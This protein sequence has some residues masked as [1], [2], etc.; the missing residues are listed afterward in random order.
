[1]KRQFQIITLVG[2]YAFFLPSCTY[3]ATNQIQNRPFEF[4]EATIDSIHAAYNSGI[5]TSV[6]LVQYYLRRIEA[7]DTHGPKINSII[8]LHPNALEQAAMLDRELQHHGMQGRLHGIPVLLKDNL[9]TF[10]LPTSNGSAILKNVVPMKDAFL[11]NELRKAGAIILGKASM[12]EFAAG[13]YNTVNG[14][15][16]NPYNFKRVPGASSGGS[17][18]AIAANFAV[19]AIGTDTS[20][21]VR[22]P[23]AYNGIVGLRPTTGLISRTGI[24]PKSLNFDTAGPMARTVSDVAYMLEVIAVVDPE[25]S[26][27]SLVWDEVAR[28]YEI[29]DGRVEYIKLLN[30]N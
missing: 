2:L 16:I 3:F 8:T 13:S 6:D 20:T 24:A 10:D 23:A 17:G 25:D 14:Q 18:A 5:L 12:G 9:D 19:L 28:Q 27:S 7:Y 26:K 30:A 22:Q 15:A 11:V 21:S 1:M 4:E 29:T